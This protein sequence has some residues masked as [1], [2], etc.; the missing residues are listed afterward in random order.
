MLHARA[1]WYCAEK[2]VVCKEEYKVKRGN[3][4]LRVTLAFALLVAVLG[5]PVQHSAAQTGDAPTT[6][7]VRIE[8]IS[9]Q[10]ALP[11]P[12]SPGVWAVHSDPAPFFTVGEP[13]RGDG[14]A[15]IAE[16]GNPAP[17]G[18]ALTSQTGIT[19]SGIFNTPV[20]AESPGPL[21]PGN[22]YEFTFTTTSD[23]PYLSLASMLVETNDVF[24]GPGEAGIALFDDQGNPLPA[25]DI[26]E[27]LP[28]WDVGSERNQAPGMGPDQVLQAG[29]EVGFREGGVYTQTDTTRAL[30][31]P[32]GIMDIEVEL[33][34]DTFT[35]TMTNLSPTGAL[36]T[37][38]SPLFYATHTSD[39]ELFTEGASDLG[40]GLEELAEDGDNSV[41]IT[42]VDALA[43]TDVVDS[44]GGL[45]AGTSVSFDIT[46]TADYPYLT[47]ATMVVYSND[48]FLAFDP[49]GI[50]L[51]NDLGNPRAAD[52]IADDIVSQLAVWDAGTEANQ[53]PAAGIYQPLI[54]GPAVGPADPD[55]T[56]RRYDDTTNDLEGPFGGGFSELSIEN[57]SGTDGFTVT[58][59]NSSNDTDFQGILT[60]PV[61][62][63]HTDTVGFFQ[64]AADASAGLEALAEDG[65]TSTLVSELEPLVGTDVGIVGSGA[66]PLMATDVYTLVVTPTIDYPYLSIASMVVPTNDT[67]MAFGPSGIRLLDDSGDPITGTE[68]LDATSEFIAWDAGT[69]RNQAG[70]AGPDQPPRQAGP[71]TGADEGDGTVRLLNNPDPVWY[72][73]ALENVLRATIIPQVEADGPGAVFAATNA[74][75]GNEV[76]MYTQGDDGRLTYFASFATGGTGSGA[77]LAAPVDPLGSQD[78]LIVYGDW[79]FVVNAG[80]NEIS[81]FSI[82]RDGLQLVDTVSSGGDYPISLTAY[83]GWLYVLNIGTDASISGFSI[84]SDGSLTP[85]DGST[86]S[87]SAANSSPPNTLQAPSQVSFSPDGQFLVVTEKASNEINVFP[88]GTDGL[89]STDPVVTQSEGVL[90]F[91]FTFADD[92]TL[93]VTEV[94]GQGSAPPGNGAVSSYTINSDGTLTPI[95]TSEPNLQTATCWI[96]TAGP[97]A[98]VSNTASDSVSSYSIA[99]DGSI[100]LL[101]SQAFTTANGAAPLDMTVL[102]NYIYVLNAALGR[103]TS[104]EIDP[105]DGSVVSLSNA[106]STLAEAPGSAGLA[107]YDFEPDT[108]EPPDL[109]VPI[110]LSI[111]TTATLSDTVLLGGVQLSVTIR[112]GTVITDGTGNTISNNLYLRLSAVDGTTL[113]STPDNPLDR[114]FSIEIVD[115][116]TEQPIPGVT[117]GP[118]LELSISYTDGDLSGTNE[119][120]LNVVLLEGTAWVTDGVSITQRNPDSNSLLATV[121]SVGTFGLNTVP[122]QEPEPPD[123]TLY[124]PLVV[125]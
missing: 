78:S 90:P 68:L 70:A 106:V 16:D 60:P 82:S 72:Y 100:S 92:G 95:T 122:T 115:G 93:L 52:D 119:D 97:Y 114:Y 9:E 39:W 67:F 31:L 111:D 85:L 3:T 59:T 71:D 55:N 38:L 125:K 51:V 17:L 18:A 30:P 45:P 117:F 69:E 112:A 91:S 102:D 56:V 121:D 21:L 89:P 14:L 29:P 79:L 65:I 76:V 53:T 20:G 83:E 7:T 118:P 19:T 77:G 33:I 73:P 120:E 116:T 27:E 35:F 105:T 104:Y 48:A 84:G 28:F 57:I 124:L 94:V 44:A 40:E 88:V 103:V 10:S 41:L 22:T 24:F 96:V 47:I 110:D 61:W 54:G 13:D 50:A 43:A 108:P 63:V 11:Q 23:A 15:A 99:T 81:S 32:D 1:C 64:I 101:E 123:N 86:R 2:L 4:I 75:E 46:P 66:V 74:P 107:A 113:A 26:T 49:S 5:M 62:A 6:F 87:L 58:L 25:R 98:Y 109:G 37:P 42:N 34:N 12:L 8:N 36:T 80:S